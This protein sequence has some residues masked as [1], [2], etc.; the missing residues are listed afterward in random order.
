MERAPLCVRPYASAEDFLNFD[1]ERVPDCVIFDIH[2]P[3]MSEIELQKELAARSSRIPVIFATAHGDNDTAV[4]ALKDGAA[5][6]LPKPVK[7]ERLL[8]AIEKAVEAD[9]RGHESQSRLESALALWEALT[10]REKEVA[11]G[12]VRGE[13]NKQVAD[14]MGITEKPSRHTEAHCCSSS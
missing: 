4:Q 3:G 1:D 5:D 11:R 10:P 13:L 6:F 9:L 12:I 14:R 7:A 8:L 2:M